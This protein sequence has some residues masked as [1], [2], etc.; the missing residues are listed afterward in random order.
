M[1]CAGPTRS[2]TVYSLRTESIV[3]MSSEANC[4]P[5]EPPTG[6]DHWGMREPQCTH[7]PVASSTLNS[8]TVSTV[9][10]PSAGRFFVSDRKCLSTLGERRGR[11][12]S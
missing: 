6:S 1:V 2:L 8:K 9:D 11:K 7:S 5:T 4:S 3:G 12:S 10:S